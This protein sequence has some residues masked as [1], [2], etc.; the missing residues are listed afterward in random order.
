MVRLIGIAVV[1][2]ALASCMKNSTTS[3]ASDQSPPSNSGSTSSQE[4]EWAAIGQLE[5]QAKSLAKT[6]GCNAS[7]DCATG[8]IGRKACGSP[9]DYLVYCKRTTDVAA[10]NAK[11]EEIVKAEAA[12]NAKYQ[13]VSTCEMRLPPEVEASG[14]S[15]RAR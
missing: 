7:D 1:S 6:D 3:G 5:A 12:Y 2:V 9:R 10:L 8:A 4:S 15:C 13:V 11:L 14:G